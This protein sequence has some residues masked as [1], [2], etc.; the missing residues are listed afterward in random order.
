MDAEVA[1]HCGFVKDAGVALVQFED[2]LVPEAA[3]SEDC[4]AVVNMGVEDHHEARVVLASAEEIARISE[5]SGVADGDEGS[6]RGQ[7]CGWMALL[8]RYRAGI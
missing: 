5:V 4:S 8:R 6:G 7:R 2:G 1:V 3:A